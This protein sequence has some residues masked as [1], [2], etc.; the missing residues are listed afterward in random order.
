MNKGFAYIRSRSKCKIYRYEK[1]V[2]LKKHIFLFIYLFYELYFILRV[3]YLLI[4]LFHSLSIYD[5]VLLIISRRDNLLLSQGISFWW[6]SYHQ[7][8]CTAAQKQVFAWCGIYISPK[9]LASFVA[10]V[11][12][13]RF[14]I[15]G[16]TTSE[17]ECGVKYALI[18]EIGLSIERKVF[19]IQGRFS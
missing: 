1:N 4:F 2:P 8:T 17:S 9:K 6:H 16:K 15:C 10:A 3:F 12:N 14:H 11:F 19:G 13:F 18:Y 5:F 7:A